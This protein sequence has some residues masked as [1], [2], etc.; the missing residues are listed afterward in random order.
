MLH[1]PVF[2]ASPLLWMHLITRSKLWSRQEQLWSRDWVFF[3]Q[4]GDWAQNTQP[5]RWTDLGFPKQ[6]ALVA[7]KSMK[8][9]DMKAMKSCERYASSFACLLCFLF[10]SLKD[11]PLSQKPFQ[12]LPKLFQ[13]EFW[14]SKV[15]V[16]D[17][18]RWLLAIWDG[19]HA[20][21]CGCVHVKRDHLATS[22]H[23]VSENSWQT[24]DKCLTNFRQMS[25]KPS[26]KCP[27]NSRQNYYY[28]RTKL[29]KVRTLQFLWGKGAMQA[30]SLIF[31]SL[32]L[33]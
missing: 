19:S 26:D 33:V 31:L 17:S 9:Q 22:S 28:Y 2:D 27:T 11:T 13:Q 32:L 16:I 24:S 10:R 7:M 6:G 30:I 25:D 15:L 5:S 29:D 12:G 18:D 3:C 14:L 21:S 20:V 1:G 23:S 4:A 8:V